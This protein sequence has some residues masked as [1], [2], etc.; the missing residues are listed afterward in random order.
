MHYRLLAI[1]VALVAVS[2]VL[3][4]SADNSIFG[5]TGL[6]RVPSADVVSAPGVVG[7][8]YFVNDLATAAAVNVGLLPNVE[9]TPGWVDPDGG[10]SSLMLS[11]KWQIWGEERGR[12]ALAVG[13]ID[14]T[15]EFDSTL[16][17]VV[18]KGF[19]F[20]QTGV[21]V[22]AGVGTR[23]AFLDGFFCGAEFMLRDGVSAMVEYD[24]EDVN[25]GARW[26]VADRMVLTVGLVNEDLGAGLQYRFK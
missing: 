23:R 9:I 26:A 18:Q 7:S 22:M 6:L 14:A 5:P 20:G 17:G 1:A 16:Y 2:L 15:D 4:V 3:P 11:G 25:I 19:S 13:L 21:N 12:P 24:G 10:D 8:V